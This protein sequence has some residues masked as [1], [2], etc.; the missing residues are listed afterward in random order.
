MACKSNVAAFGEHDCEAGSEKRK[1]I[2][3]SFYSQGIEIMPQRVGD[4][5]LLVIHE[6]RFDFFS[7]VHQ[8]L[9]S[10]L[11]QI[12]PSDQGEIIN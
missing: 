3:R 1:L 5:C 11:H 9:H 8:A 10:P 2:E 6:G 12:C 4:Y 7:P